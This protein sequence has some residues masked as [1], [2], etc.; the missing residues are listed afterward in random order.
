M[1]DFTFKPNLERLT[2]YPHQERIL[3]SL[4][5][6]IYKLFDAGGDGWTTDLLTF[7]QRQGSCENTIALWQELADQTYGASV[8]IR[9]GNMEQAETV[10]AN[11]LDKLPQVARHD[12]PSI[13]VKFWRICL[14]LDG[15]DKCTGGI[16][17]AKAR[18]LRR[19]QE[20]FSERDGGRHLLATMVTSLSEVP[21]ADFRDTLRIGFD[22]T[23]RTITALVGDENAMILHMWSHFFKYWNK[24]SLDTGALFRKFQEVW[25]KVHD[26]NSVEHA[27]ETISAHYYYAYAAYYL[28]KPRDFGETM[29]T[30]LFDRTERFFRS[31]DRPRWSLIALAFAFSARITA[32]VHRSAGRRHLCKR[33]MNL[34]IEK[35]E[36]GDRECMTRAAMLSGILAKWLE[37]WGHVEESQTES[38]RAAGIRSELEDRYQTVGA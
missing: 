29:V 17:N 1:G 7:T 23:L 20:I 18:L 19:L 26:R 12:D 21:S 24:K 3:S 34:A 30:Q 14:G 2:Q 31:V 25:M 15:L 16:F 32:L 38:L 13:F 35:L 28:W 33:V 6:Y 5:C 36:S 9:S 22:K 8:L 37:K 4:D 10:L 27:E 11:F